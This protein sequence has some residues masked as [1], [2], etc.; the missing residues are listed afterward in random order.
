MATGR[1]VLQLFV[2]RYVLNP[3]VILGPWVTLGVVSF[4]MLIS[5]R[6][7]SADQG[8]AMGLLQMLFL[9]SG[10]EEDGVYARYLWRN[11]G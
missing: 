2:I 6:S 1:M 10:W 5:A 11:R 3:F 4:M 9:P 8:T 7:H